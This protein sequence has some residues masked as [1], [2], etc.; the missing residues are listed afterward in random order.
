MSV[1]ELKDGTPAAR[2]H[3][4]S[5]SALLC[6]QTAARALMIF[7]RIHTYMRS[8]LIMCVCVCFPKIFTALREALERRGVMSEMRARMRSEVFSVMEDQE[9]RRRAMPPENAVINELIREYLTYNDY[10]HT[11]NVFVPEAALP[12]APLDRAYIAQQAQLPMGDPADAA[13]APL[14]LLYSLF[15]NP[16]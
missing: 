7:T 1:E 8:S 11:L 13:P 14:P 6:T 16:S 2:S 10:G 4:T 9:E 5:L 12:A 15:T 3:I